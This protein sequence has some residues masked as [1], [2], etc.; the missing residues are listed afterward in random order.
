MGVSWDWKQSVQARL[1]SSHK[2]S[3][4]Y[5]ILCTNGK[6]SH[7]HEDEFSFQRNIV[8]VMRLVVEKGGFHLE[9]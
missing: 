5:V 2:I 8:G 4:H 1:K 6:E 9:D 3:Q 7:T